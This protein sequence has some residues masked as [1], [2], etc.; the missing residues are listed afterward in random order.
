MGTESSFLSAAAVTL[1]DSPTPLPTFVHS[2]VNYL[3]PS[4]QAYYL[5]IQ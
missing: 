3:R 5:S 1:L 4:H 2:T